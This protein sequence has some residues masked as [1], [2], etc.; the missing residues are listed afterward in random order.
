MK[1]GKFLMLVVLISSIAFT[2]CK[3]D[4][5]TGDPSTGNGS[6]T[7]KHAGTSWSA[8]LAV[9]AVNTNGVINVTGS[10]SEARQAAITL[11]GVSSPGTY[12]IEMGAQHSGRWTEGADPSQ[13]YVSNGVI[14]TGTITITELSDTK[15]KGSFSFEAFNTAQTSKSITEGAFDVTF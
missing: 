4:D 15:I 14:G 13:T 5:D 8:S 11:F 3:K 12:K 2:S 10:D 1:A 7:L 9:Q 6:M